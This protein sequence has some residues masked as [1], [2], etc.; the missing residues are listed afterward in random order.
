MGGPGRSLVPLLASGGAA[1]RSFGDRGSTQLPPSGTIT[2]GLNDQLVSLSPCDDWT[3]RVRPL[4]LGSVKDDSR[5]LQV[6]L[7]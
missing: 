4:S 1:R 3:P 6:G 7:C 5:C 2:T